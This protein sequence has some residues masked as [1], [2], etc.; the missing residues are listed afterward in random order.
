MYGVVDGVIAELLCPLGNLEL[1]LAS[2]CLSGISLLEVGLGVPN[3]LTEELCELGSV[4][5][6]LESISLECVCNLWI[7]LALCLTAHGQIHSNFGALTVEVVVK[8]LENLR[9]LYLSVTEPVLASP[10][11]SAFLFFDFNEL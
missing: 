7:A 11:W 6:L 10:L 9:V 8:T 5:C 4:L 2:A 1:A 3:H